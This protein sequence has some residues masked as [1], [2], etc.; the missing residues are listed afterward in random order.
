MGVTLDWF[1]HGPVV[2]GNGAGLFGPLREPLRLDLVEARTFPSGTVIH[3]YR[4]HE[5]AR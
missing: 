4:P 5:E 2:I 3:T 1:V